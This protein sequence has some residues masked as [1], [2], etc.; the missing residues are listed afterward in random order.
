[1]PNHVVHW[2]IAAKDAQKQLDFYSTLFEW[3]IN[4]TVP[5]RYAMVQTGEP[6]INGGIF[7]VGESGRP[8]ITFYVQVDNLE[9]C[10]AKVSQLGGKVMVQPTPVPGIGSMAM[11]QDP[12]GNAIG[13]FRYGYP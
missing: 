4:A 13:L 7:A 12:E 6:G 10:L 2:E 1:M 3:K 8:P 11:F 9:E 5:L